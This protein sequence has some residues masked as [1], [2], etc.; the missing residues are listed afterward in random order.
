MRG[1]KPARNKTKNGNVSNFVPSLGSNFSFARFCPDRVFPK[2]RRKIPRLGLNYE[3]QVKL[4]LFQA[5][6]DFNSLNFD[7]LSGNFRGTPPLVPIEISPLLNSIDIYP[8]GYPRSFPPQF[9]FFSFCH[10]PWIEYQISGENF[11]RFCSPDFIIFISSFALPDHLNS[12]YS[13]SNFLKETYLETSFL[14]SALSGELLNPSG[15]FLY[16]N[17][18]K[19][20]LAEVK[21]S[22]VEISHQK[23]SQLYFPLVEIIFPKIKIQN[24]VICK[25]LTPASP[26][27]FDSISSSL[28]SISSFK[29]LQ[30]LGNGKLKL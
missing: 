16:K 14:P 23:L 30:W 20:I 28:N 12:S 13:R 19:I 9:Y 1:L 27:A 21:L 10:N 15:N 6:L 2:T 5:C 24:L 3:K 29:L 26:L 18:S 22:Y 7:S 8:S 17:L 25:N 4:A 11:S